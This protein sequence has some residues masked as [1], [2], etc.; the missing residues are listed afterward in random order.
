MTRHSRL[1][2]VG[3]D[4]TRC[5]GLWDHAVSLVSDPSDEDLS[6]LSVFLLG[7]RMDSWVI[8]NAG[9]TGDVAVCVGVIQHEIGL[10]RIIHQRKRTD[11]PSG[12]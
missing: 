2:E 9:F 6:G 8:D 11:F 1:T 7:H 5:N 10:R 12:L 3:L 4:P